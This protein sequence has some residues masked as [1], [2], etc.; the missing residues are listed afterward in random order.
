MAPTV[1][2]NWVCCG[3]EGYTFFLY[4]GAMYTHYTSQINT[5]SPPPPPPGMIAGGSGITPMYQVANAILKNRYDTTQVTLIYANVTKED[6]LLR[7]E[8]DAWAKMHPNFTVHY[9]LNSPPAGWT[10]STGFVT[11][12]IIK[13]HMPGPDEDCMVL[14]CGPPPMNKAVEGHLNTLGYPS[15]KLFEF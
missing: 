4:H 14:R 11:A 12:D 6:I 7:E 10:G 9:V 2:P 5:L 13:Q 15:E 8:L 1:L 3:V